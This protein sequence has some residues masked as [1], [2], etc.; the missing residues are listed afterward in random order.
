MAGAPSGRHDVQVDAARD[1]V[2]VGE[3]VDLPDDPAVD[4]GAPQEPGVPERPTELVADGVTAL[5]VVADVHDD[6]A[7]SLALM[8]AKPM[9]SPATACQSIS[10]WWFETSMP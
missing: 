10:P 2:D 4:V 7:P 8:Y 9:P 5:P 6:L 1:A 3:A